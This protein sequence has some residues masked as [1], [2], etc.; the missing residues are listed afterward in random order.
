M[1]SKS[2]IQNLKSKIGRVHIL[3][4]ISGFVLCLPS[5]MVGP[6]YQRPPA[7]VPPTYKEAPPQSWKGTTWQQAQPSDGAAKGNWWEI[8]KD[9]ELDSLENQV[10]ISN[11][12]V[13]LA[14]AQFEEARDAVRV[15]RSE[16]FPTVSASPTY[17]SLRTS[18]T[19]FN[20]TAGNL[21]SGVR[22][23][24]DLPFQ[25]SYALDLW[26]S[27]RRT[28]RGIGE[29]AQASFATLANARLTYQAELAEDYYEL[30]GTDQEEDLLQ[31]T[32]KL[33]QDY[34]KLTQ[35]QF[36]Q[37]VASGATVALAE[38]QLDAAKVQ[39]VSYGVARAQYEHAIAVLTGK[40]PT[41][42]SIPHGPI[43][44][45]PPPVPLG[46]PSQLLERR[47]DIATAERMMAVA[48]EQIGIAEAA[49]YPSLTLS[50]T[51]GFESGSL[52]RWFNIPSGFWSLG[53]QLAE[54]LVDFG[55]RRW[56]VKQEE[57]AYDGDVANYRQTVLTAFQQVEDNLAALR[58]LENEAKA[59][60]LNVRAAQDSLNL[61]RYQYISGIVNY[62]NVI[63][64]QTTLLTDQVTAVGIQMSRMTA[65]VLL[66]E[67]LGG[68]WNSSTIPTLKSLAYAH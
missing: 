36:Q 10:N 66:V 3:T 46:V 44:L 2:K 27:I 11:Q 18:A 6:K 68:G 16:L 59:E 54:T 37:G 17:T 26:G 21:T 64:A 32:V 51:A 47:P 30:R 42:L 40:P 8:Y 55:K 7:P 48:N 56:T 63:T 35:E 60:D 20:A 39:L 31:S 19:E 50:A 45:T 67:Y 52:A 34:L 15:A 29:T 22:S 33:Y 53:P 9:P 41:E 65:S 62:L 61:E 49:Y 38:T 1:T 24:Y 57:A 5:C 13:A 12:N 4:I 14:A 43:T 28:Y 25:A 23:L 58:I